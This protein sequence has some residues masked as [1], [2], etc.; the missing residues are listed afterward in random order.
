MNFNSAEFLLFLPAVLLLNTLLF[1][2]TRG[3]HLML[4]VA[5]YAFYMAWNWK[6]A[7]LI[8][9]STLIDYFVGLRMAATDDP[10]RRKLL[11]I[12][13][14]C[15]NLGVLALFKYFNFFVDGTAS[16]F[17]LIGVDLAL[18]T[19]S[20]LLPVGISFYTFQTLSYTIDLYWRRLEPERDLG[21]FAL[22]VSFFPQLVAGPIVRASDFLPQLHHAPESI[23][24][25][26][27][28]VR[29]GMARIFRGLFKK[30]VFADLIAALFV[31]KVFANPSDYSTLDLLL[32]LYG[33]AF[34]IYN[35]FSGYSDIAIG[36]AMLLGFHIPENF[37]RPYLSRNVREFWT[38][39]HISLSSW[40]KDYLYIP[41][42][43]N[44]GGRTARNLMITMGLGGL[45]HGAG[46]NFVLWGVYH[47]LLLIASRAADRHASPDAPAGVLFRDR[48]L[49]FHLV[50]GGWLL[51]RVRDMDH[52][53]E[54]ATA[55]ATFSGGTALHPAA[56]GLLALAALVHFTPRGAADG[57]WKGWSK[58]PEVIQGAGYAAAIVLLCGLSVDAAVFIYFQF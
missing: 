4:L 37:N 16:V 45:W 54:Y 17:E 26:R 6:Y 36:A 40:L 51:F 1:G 53:A 27:Q 10:R 3:R 46:L 5:S 34:Q 14:L 28:R 44:R 9:G 43:G 2:R 8:A 47:G 58:L 42:G 12:V 23:D 7:G 49:T 52:L 19:H 25:S 39:W 55:F 15:V 11:L 13:S 20:L 21:K 50:L 33:Y 30:I 18:P 22:F 56:I 41:L 29:A 31:D 35:D 57:L 48:F 24:G 32:A 38:R